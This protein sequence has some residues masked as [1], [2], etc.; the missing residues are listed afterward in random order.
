MKI[1]KI[2]EI[3]KLDRVIE[4]SI[5]ACI[6]M[7]WEMGKKQHKTPTKYTCD[8]DKGE[9]Y[10]L[11]IRQQILSLIEEL[12]GK[13]PNQQVNSLCNSVIMVANK[14]INK[15]KDGRARSVETLSDMLKIK[16]EAE[17]LKESINL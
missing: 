7:G 13:L 17:M 10:F 2:K 1:S 6:F 5:R 16:Q 11:K 14:F 4:D 8:T 12:E 9:K 3:N 15:C